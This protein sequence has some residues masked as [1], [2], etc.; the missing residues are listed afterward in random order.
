MRVFIVLDGDGT[1]TFTGTNQLHL[2][3]GDGTFESGMNISE[4]GI[5]TAIVAGDFN[6]DNNLDVVV[7][8][9][10]V[11][12][13]RLYI[14]NGDGTFECVISIGRLWDLVCGSM[15]LLLGDVNGDGNLDIATAV[16]LGVNQLFLGNGNGSFGDAIDISDDEDRSADITILPVR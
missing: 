2:G 16:L 15:L 6:N 5:F 1:V 3:N 8:G 12:T 9:G 4:T 13:R 7:V 14:G 11:P 10:S